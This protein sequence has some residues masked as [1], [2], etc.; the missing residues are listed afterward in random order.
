[1]EVDNTFNHPSNSIQD[2][3]PPKSI[4]SHPNPS[5]TSNKT[6]T[7]Q[8]KSLDK[9]LKDTQSVQP[10]I[11]CKSLD[12]IIKEMKIENRRSKLKNQKSLSSDNSNSNKISRK[13]LTI[14]PSN[15][16]S[17]QNES[18]STNTVVLCTDDQLKES[19]KM[20]KQ[21]PPVNNETHVNNVDKTQVSEQGV[22]TP[23][24]ISTV[25][26]EDP[27]EVN[28]L[29]T[30]ANSYALQNTNAKDTIS[31]ENE[32]CHVNNVR[33]DQTEV[34]SNSSKG[35]DKNTFIKE[36][37]TDLRKSKSKCKN[38]INFVKTSH[39]TSAKTIESD[40]KQSERKDRDEG[41]KHI[42]CDK[43]SQVYPSKTKFDVHYESKCNF[44]L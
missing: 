16:L 11:Q 6:P 36:Q 41:W 40:C 28:S 32:N 31:L 25:V 4:S 44:M 18:L 39:E 38:K 2:C 34:L 15:A 42:K 19:N 20:S 35:I 21:L 5:E 9:M 24:S 17:K 8:C 10:S 22:H 23:N 27:I 3:T 37:I 13:E 14:L 29:K 1:M 26:L 7:I 33:H 43:C 12:K 30:G